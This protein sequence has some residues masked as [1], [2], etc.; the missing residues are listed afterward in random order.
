MTLFKQATQADVNQD[1]RAAVQLYEQCAQTDALPH[2]REAALLN[3]LLIYWNCTFDYGLYCSLLAAGYT[4]SE[5]EH[6]YRRKNEIEQV[7]T[8]APFPSYEARFWVSYIREEESYG[9]ESAHSTI[10][11]LQ[12]E[13]PEEPLAAYYVVNRAAPQVTDPSTAGAP[14]WALAQLEQLQAGLDR[15]PQ[16]FKN[17]RIL[18]HIGSMLRFHH[19]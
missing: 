3:L 17:R 6:M 16:T 15:E 5:L 9:K 18:S 12:H 13:C 10:A 1:L 14:A 2:T 19:L 4:E 7:L 11:H 8:A